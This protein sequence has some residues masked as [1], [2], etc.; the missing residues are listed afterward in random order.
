MSSC[1]E[2]GLILK[3]S[4]RCSEY[5][6][7]TI[8]YYRIIP[9]YWQSRTQYSWMSRIGTDLSQNIGKRWSYILTIGILQKCMNETMDTSLKPCIGNMNY[10]LLVNNHRLARPWP[11][12]RFSYSSAR[13]LT[14][15]Y[16]ADELRLTSG[17]VRK[18]APPA[19]GV[20]LLSSWLSL[21]QAVKH[22]V[23]KIKI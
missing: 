19:L 13:R 22:R 20:T 2:C 16:H 12:P 15:S 1:I 18:L 6:L 17:D 21:S 10:L 7:D 4:T 11:T 8:P 14:P 9:H 5:H 3:R 23:F